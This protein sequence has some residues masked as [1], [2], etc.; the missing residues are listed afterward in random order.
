MNMK[1][2]LLTSY[3]NGNYTV[4]LFDDGT[5]IRETVDDEFVPVY[6]E[7][8]DVHISDCC[9]NGCPMCYADCSPNGEFADLN[10]P[11]IETLM[12]G[13]ELALN[14]NYPFHPE[15][16]PF[17]KKLMDKGVIANITINQKHF[18]EHLDF[19]NMLVDEKLVYGIGVSLTDPTK[20][21]IHEIKRYPNAVI[22]TIA[23]ILTKEQLDE[24]SDNN[25]K[26]LILGYKIKGRGNEYLSRH[27]EVADRIKW[28][29]TNIKSYVNKFKVISFDNLALEQLNVKD[30]LST[31]EWDEFYQGDD[32]DFTFFINMVD[33]TFCKNSLVPKES[34][35]IYPVLS[36]VKDMFTIIRSRKGMK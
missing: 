16:I 4:I 3:I 9:D 6:P 5:K 15:L 28:L 20:R 25:L 35:E 34:T 27:V 21:F 24:L 18:M 12:P 33:Q 8:C 10:Q 2:K 36:N 11:W 29:S 22:H 26:I 14:L 31:K 17:L 32:G 1:K 7:C 30:I 23:G 13:M 19:I